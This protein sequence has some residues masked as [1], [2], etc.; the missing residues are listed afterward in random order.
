VEGQVY[1]ADGRPAANAR[2]WLWDAMA[3]E[4]E[5][6]SPETR[7]DAQGRYVLTGLGEGRH[8]LFAECPEETPHYAQTLVEVELGESLTWDAVLETETELRVRIENAEGQP[9]K[10]AIVLVFR[11]DPGPPWAD[12]LHTDREGRVHFTQLVDHDLALLVR[13]STADP[14]LERYEFE[15]DGSEVVIRLPATVTVGCSLRGR[16]IDHQGRIPRGAK[17]VGKSLSKFFVAP[18]DVRSGEFLAAAL[19][20]GT[21]ELMAVVDERGAAHIG[22]ATIE[23]GTE[24]DVGTIQLPQPE[25]VAIEWFA[26]E[27]PSAEQPWILY[28]AFPCAEDE[29]T[30]RALVRPVSEMTLLPG[31]YRLAPAEDAADGGRQLTVGTPKEH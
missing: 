30:I 15:H 24:E 2:V 5:Q 19:E 28:A 11:S 4:R 25:T 1:L 31:Y 14:E 23:R 22:F 12:V 13:G 7:T 3:K 8:Y 6:S 17:V 20:P 26:G 27:A 10:E 16:L 21:Y 18:A 9:V 29:R